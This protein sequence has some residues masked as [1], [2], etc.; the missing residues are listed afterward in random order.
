MS[1]SG[2]REALG[3]LG[4]DAAVEARDRLALLRPRGAAEARRIAGQRARIAAL[5]V[6]HGFTHV[7]LEIG[8]VATEDDAALPGD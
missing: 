3:T 1:A 8:A 7:A 2:L 4:V 6:E 5:A